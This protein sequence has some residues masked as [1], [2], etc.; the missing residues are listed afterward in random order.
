MRHLGRG[1]D[2]QLLAGRVHD[3]G[4]GLHERG[5]QALLAEAAAD[6][7]GVAVG[8]GGLDGLGHVGT[9]AG[10]SGVEHPGRGDVGAE[11]RVDE[12]GAVL[13]GGLHVEDRLERL[14][15]DLDELGGVARGGGRPGD[16]DGDTLTGEVD[17]ADG[18]H[19]ALRG[20]LVR[21]DRPRAGHA[22]L[23]R[24][25]VGRGVDA[26]HTRG[27]LG[28]GLVDRGDGRP[29]DRRPDDGDVDG[30]RRVMESV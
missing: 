22:D 25:E 18:E 15:V 10:R 14:V 6:D 3:A 12:L 16:D 21:G 28:L 27:L 8:L 7:D 9:G 24:T 11:V 26:E 5:D 19:R 4:A 30:P 13:R 20:L 29:R 2:R 17:A 1:P 23:L